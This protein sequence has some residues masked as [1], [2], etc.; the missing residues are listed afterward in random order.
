MEIK[1]YIKDV[2][3]ID[4]VYD[5]GKYIPVILVCDDRNIAETMVTVL[6]ISEMEDDFY[7]DVV[8]IHNTL[9]EY[10]LAAFEY[11]LN[12]LDASKLK[13]R[14][15]RIEHDFTKGYIHIDANYKKEYVLKCFLPV[16][17]KRYERFLYVRSG[18]VL[19]TGIS[20]FYESF[21][22]VHELGVIGAEKLAEVVVFDSIEFR[23]RYSVADIKNSMT[24]G[25]AELDME[26]L[27]KLSGSISFELADGIVEIYDDERPS[28]SFKKLI[29]RVPYFERWLYERNNG[30][31]ITGGYAKPLNTEFYLFP[32]ELVQRGTKVVLYG[33]GK[34][35]KLFRQQIEMTHFCE[36]IAVVDRDV[37]EGILAPSELADL[38]C[39]HVV[40]AIANDRVANEIR[41]NLMLEG[42]KADKII[43][44][45]GRKL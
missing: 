30:T 13:L 40:I 17:L 43:Y 29:S 18:N 14:F 10:D 44:A 16:I 24:K 20:Q 7:Y 8:I 5:K 36:L 42:I 3:F 15:E 23:M 38:E 12:S 45:T 31:G 2:S 26:Y 19:K 37:K 35:G 39:D 22:G 1:D 41:N 21:T 4:P 28:I 32:F 25:I 11:M 33:N 34:V 27:K 9:D 6:S